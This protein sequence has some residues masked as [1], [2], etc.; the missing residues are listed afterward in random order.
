MNS[1]HGLVLAFAFATAGA[2]AACGAGA[3]GRAAA[4]AGPLLRHESPSAE[5][6]IYALVVAHSFGGR[7]PDTLLLVS[8]SPTYHDLPA[9]NFLRRGKAVVPPPLP[10]RL[11][12]LS[13]GRAPA[14][15][16]AFPAPVRTLHT[17]SAQRLATERL[18]GTKV[19]AVT[20]VA[21]TDDSVQALV[22]YEVWC[23]RACGGRY[24]LWLVRGPDGRW[25]LR[26]EITHWA[27]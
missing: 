21:F 26:Q 11:S 6:E 16:E 18:G 1:S 8:E 20:P 5:R 24:E 15:V 13:A 22:Y 7:R 19:L 9:D 3:V 27:S 25:Q 23:G 12:A 2:V 10:R 17:E 14:D 4:H